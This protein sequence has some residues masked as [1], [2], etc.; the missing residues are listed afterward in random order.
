MMNSTRYFTCNLRK[1]EFL[2]SEQNLIELALESEK[3]V[4]EMRSSHRNISFLATIESSKI[5]KL[6]Q[7]IL[8]C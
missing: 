3:S 7:T 4:F 2:S 1:P 5:D 6:V 8:F